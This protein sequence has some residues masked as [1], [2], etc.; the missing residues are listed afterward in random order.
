MKVLKVFAL[1]ILLIALGVMGYSGYQLFKTEQIYQEGNSNYE[2]LRDQV[3]VTEA[4]VEEITTTIRHDRTAETGR[5]DNIYETEGLDK[6][7]EKPQIYIP[8]IG[9]NFDV[10]KS[11][12][13]DAAAWLYCP[14]TLI[15]YPVMKAKDYS[16]YLT[17]LPDGKYNANGSLFID[18]N[19]ASD[20]SDSLTVIYGHNM[21][22]KA[23][24]GSLTEYKMQG[25]Y[26]KH[27]YM[28]LFT[29]QK[30]YRIEL[31]YGCVTDAGQ[32]REQGFM[33]AENI[34]KFMAYA[35]QNTTFAS[36]VKYIEGDRIVVLSTCSY[37]FNNARYVVIGILREG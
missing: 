11:I 15:D 8:G 36:D 34:G 17:H 6:A 20:F 3:R 31:M 2:D 7:D 5:T 13:K 19:N 29:E 28:Y 24:F 10:L 22:S 33:F 26:E 27:P 35:A 18:Y 30:S 37:E 1:L 12:S 25:Y 9:I 4:P 14:D 32:W 23:M 16:Y 21:K